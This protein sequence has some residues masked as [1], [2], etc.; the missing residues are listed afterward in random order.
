ML[1]EHQVRAVNMLRAA[2]MK[3]N[4]RPILAAPC[5]FGKT[6]TAVH[7]LSEAVKKGR[8]GIFIC[9]RIKLVQQALEAFDAQGIRVGVMQGQ[10]QRTDYAAPIQIASIQTLSKK[11][12]LPIFHVAVVDECHVHYK[13]LQEMMDVMS[14]VTFIGLSATPF[15]KGL[16]DSYNDLIVPI[17]PLEL[18]DKGYLCPVDYYGGASADLKGVRSKRLSTGG[19]DYDPKSLSEAIEGDSSL[20][21]DIIK[22]WIAHGNDA[23]TIAFSP[24]IAHSKHMVEMFN[25][26]GI[27]AEHIDGYMD[28]EE[29]EFIYAG[30]DAGEFKILSCSRLL[31]TGYDAPKVSCLI[32]CFPTKSLISFVQRAGRIMRTAE[33]KDKAVY[34]DHAGNVARHGFAEHIVPDVLHQGKDEYSDRSLTKEKPEPKVKTCPQCFQQMVGLRCK[35]GYEFK[36]E[37]E[38]ESDSLMLEKIKRK[39]NK[40]V[41]AEQKAIWLGELLLMAKNKDYNPGW[42]NHKYREKFGVWPNKISPI[43]ATEV[44]ADVKNWITHMN[45][46]GAKRA[47]RNT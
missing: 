27:T 14:L 9:D 19:S 40:V 3:G 30:H 11:R 25:A 21:G 12:H 15:S 46:R 7:I 33:G 17:T 43:Q 47:G 20:T 2:I 13:A 38:L 28:E 44:G 8:R 37:V 34:L 22:N 32:D 10:H 4:R 1:R 26:A 5:S 35:C 39:E 36:F 41:T 45:I 16:G 31:N 24:S 29:R 23:Q 42:A 6:I 18:L